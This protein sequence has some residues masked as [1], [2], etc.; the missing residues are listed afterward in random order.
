MRAIWIRLIVVALCLTAGVATAWADDGEEHGAPAAR[1]GAGHAAGTEHGA[2]GGHDAH[3]APTFDDVNWYYGI[4]LEREGVEPSLWFRPKG[5]PVPFLGFVLNAAVLYAILYRFAKKPVSEGLAK[6]KANIERG[7]R[8]AAEHKAD[9]ARR[10]GDYEG[11]LSTIEKEVERVRR[12]MREAG[13]LER[14]RVLSDARARR[15]RMERDARLLVEQEFAAARVVLR[16]DASGEC[17]TRRRIPV[18]ALEREGHLASHAE[19]GMSRADTA[20]AERYARAIFELGVESGTAADLVGKVE[21]FASVYHSSPEFR[22]ALE[23]PRIQQSDRDAILK[24]VA[25]RLGFGPLGLNA[26]RYVA[27][28]RRL[29]ALPE[30]A[31]RLRQLIDEKAGVVRATVTTAAPLPENFYERLTR[32]LE[33]LTGQRVSL[34]RREDPS[35]IAGVVTRIGDRTIDGSLRGKLEQLGRQLQSS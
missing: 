13:E 12:D 24:T 6:R 21:A 18:R 35:L 30:I 20:A 31:Q 27:R 25:E 8:E 1:D 11:K 32:E 4:L 7:M 17:F 3:H 23:N 22:I 28:R 9:A 26:V 2:A 19:F 29:R 14:V 33:T 10:L 15:E 5:M 16:R 34:E